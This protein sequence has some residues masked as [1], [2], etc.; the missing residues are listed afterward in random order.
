MSATA[1]TADESG[2]ASAAASADERARAASLARELDEHAYRYYVLDSPTISDAEY[3]RLMAEL[4][5]LEERHPDL[6]TPDSPTQK[7]AGSYS[8]LFTPV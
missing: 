3:D 5:A 4:A 1:G 7:V 8:T 6:R 2:V